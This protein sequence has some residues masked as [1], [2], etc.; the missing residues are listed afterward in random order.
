[1]S[2]T[3]AEMFLMDGCSGPGERLCAG[4]VVF[5]EG[6]DLIPDLLW[7]GEAHAVEGGA[8]EDGEPDLDLVHP[9]CVGGGEVEVDVLVAGEPCVP[10]RLV[11]VEVVEDDVDGRVGMRGDDIVHEV[12]ELD[13]PSALLVSGHHFAGGHLEGSKQRRGPVA[14]QAVLRFGRARQAFKFGAFLRRL[15]DP[16]ASGMPL[17]HP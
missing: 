14:P 11:G 13:A 6:I 15:T 17:M 5:E 4:V 2:D 8:A 9:G 7:R 3:C 10:L 16:V 12:E 1:M